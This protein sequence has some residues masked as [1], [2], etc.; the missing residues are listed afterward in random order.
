MADTADVWVL[1]KGQGFWT[2]GKGVCV[3]G[4]NR[5]IEGQEQRPRD[6]EALGPAGQEEAVYRGRRAGSKVG[7]PGDEHGEPPTSPGGSD[8]SV[9]GTREPGRLLSGVG[10]AQTHAFEGS[11]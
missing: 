7:R 1:K 2:E 5:Q 3:A 4:Y 11:F 9:L 6:G 10:S 8:L